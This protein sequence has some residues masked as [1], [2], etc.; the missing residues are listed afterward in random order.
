MRFQVPQFIGVEDTIFGPFTAKQFV[1]LA[2][3]GALCYIIYKFLPL[4]V[5]IVI[6]APMALLSVSL[7]FIKINGKP[8]IFTLEAS[9]KY[10]LSSKIYLWKKSRVEITKQE[11]YEIPNTIV[12]QTIKEGKMDNLNNV[13]D[14]SKNK[15]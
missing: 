6:I 7:A 9:L 1:Y 14:L 3:G 15:K 13:L 5:A 10:M 4:V 12:A 11:N 8:F 2:G